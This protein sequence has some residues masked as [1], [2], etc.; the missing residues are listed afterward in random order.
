MNLGEIFETKIIDDNYLGNGITK[1]NGMVVFVIGAVKGDVVKVKITKVL[2]HYCM[3][4]I[5]SFISK[6]SF[7]CD[8]KCPY[9]EE[10]GGCNLLHIDYERENLLKKEYVDKLLNITSSFIYYDRFGYRNKVIFHVKDGKIGFYRNN[11]NVLVEINKCMLVSSRINSLLPVLKTLDLSS[12]TQIT[13]REGDGL[14]I[15]FLG[16]V[17]ETDLKKLEFLEYVK[18]IYVND[19]FICGDKYLKVHFGNYNFFVDNNS[20][21]QVNTLCAISLYEKIKEYIGGAI[22]LLDLYCGSA[23]IG[24][25][26]SGV[27]KNVTGIELSKNSFNCGLV[28]IKNNNV[29]NYEIICD[30]AS[31]VDGVYDVIVVDPPRSGLSKSV[32]SF[33]NSNSSKKIV[34]VSCNPNTLKRDIQLLSNYE[35]KDVSLFNMF[36]STLH[37]ES[38][39]LLEKV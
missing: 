34:Y 14:L 33:L 27:C 7:R 18:S 3:A 1:V 29:S 39:V 9:Y 15:S 6:S 16:D 37:I 8:V 35:I 11:S 5:I 24:I 10:C 28:N 31:N 4:R 17:L 20:F 26:L 23:T 36:P 13:I 21:L 12:V 25:Y 22:N 32:I 2:K 38:V 19:E 30:D